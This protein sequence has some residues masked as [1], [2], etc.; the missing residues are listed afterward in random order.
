V[1]I[2]NFVYNN[3]QSGIQI[4]ADSSEIEPDADGITTDAIIA[5]N[6]FYGNGL[7]G[8]AAINLDGAVNASLY[9][10]LIYDNHADGI[11]LF[12]QDADYASINAQ[13]YHNTIVNTATATGWN[14][15]ITDGS[16]GADVQNNI[17]VTLHETRGVIG[18][19]TP[20]MADFSCDY[21]ILTPRLG[22]NGDDIGAIKNLS[23]W[24]ALGYDLHS[25]G[26]LDL[27]LVFED[28]GGDD[29]HLVDWSIAVDTAVN[30]GFPFLSNDLEGN[31][32]PQGEGPDVGTYESS[33]LVP[34][35]YLDLQAIQ[36]AERIKIEWLSIGEVNV[37]NYVLQRSFDGIT[38]QDITLVT[39]KNENRNN[40]AYIDLDP[41]RSGEN[42]YRLNVIEQDGDSWHSSVVN[43]RL[44]IDLPIIKYD[45][46][47]INITNSEVFFEAEV[48][49][50]DVLGRIIFRGQIKD[51]LRIKKS[52]DWGPC[53]LVF[54][55]K[56]RYVKKIW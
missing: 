29:Y 9:N 21:N 23:E 12:R 42:Y 15:I 31:M 13:I 14:L 49:L 8:G 47:F 20:S 56:E 46:E 41:H 4:N 18:I 54:Q 34:I 10:N 52:L 1:I 36:E 16:T 35:Q 32:R 6:M 2:N 22:N 7:G 48:L 25:Q 30:L 19:D 51:Q 17:L 40:Y 27:S 55:G 39:A 45:G 50:I 24:Q 5:N 26:I 33:S 53:F 43:V 37:D 38:F 44:S 28:V 11:A 3:N